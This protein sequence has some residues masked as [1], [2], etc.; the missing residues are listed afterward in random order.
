MDLFS[1]FIF[2]FWGGGDVNPNVSTNSVELCI[3]GL[4]EVFFPFGR[5]NRRYILY[6]KAEG[7]GSVLMEYR[8]S[9]VSAR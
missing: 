9:Q 3:L 7:I 6:Y 4:S 2:F 8:P 1:A 5:L